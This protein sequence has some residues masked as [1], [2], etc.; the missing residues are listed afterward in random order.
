[1]GVA[2]LL[3]ATA[4]AVGSDGLNS[5][6]ILR[7]T[8]H[9]GLVA[10]SDPG[11]R[12]VIWD[13]GIVDVHFPAFMKRAGDYRVELSAAELE[14]LVSG[15]LADGLQEFDPALVR[16]ELV[17]KSTPTNG[18]GQIVSR[19]MDRGFTEFQYSLPVTENKGLVHGSIRWRGL[20]S[21]A[22]RHPDVKALQ[23]L[24]SIESRLLELADDSRAVRV[25]Q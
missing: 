20:Q 3:G 9:I 2:L 18:G 16:E 8:R 1:M 24:A 21:S 11:P 4:V 17:G 25:A 19:E 12:V 23:D 7:M 22:R 14:V 10:S 13:D 5:H 15:L 6:M